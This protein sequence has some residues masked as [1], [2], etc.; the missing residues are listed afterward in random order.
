MKPAWRQYLPIMT[1]LPEYTRQAASKDG[2]AA[3]IVTLMLVPQSLAYAIVAGL[4]PVYGLYA[5]ILPLVAYTLLGT[6]KTLA[7]GPVAVISLMTAEAIAPLHD[8]GTHAYVT[9]AATL[10]FLS[11]LMLLIMAVF[12]LGF[13]TTFLSHS[14]LSGFMTASGVLII[15]GQL[16]KLLGLSAAPGSL[17][18]V[19]AAV[20]YP[21]LWLGVGTLV[22]LVLGRRYFASLLQNFGC[23]ASWAGHISKLLPVMVMVASILIIDYFP[24]HTQGVS[25]VGAIP[26]GLPSFVM[27]VFETNLVVQLLPA[28]LL[29]SV[30]GFVESASVGQTLAAKRRQRIEPNQELIA[31]G[32][33]NIASAIQGGFP[34]TGGTFSFSG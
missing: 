26:T 28:A 16:P 23:S 30:V 9:A 11:G 2:V 32:G 33:A 6:S 27:P 12:R 29:I 18:E 14:V 10:A 22:L 34:V 25:V 21:T 13:L 17:T 31:L 3:L 1:W 5:S 19:L 7:V 20:H 4:P 24:Q 15:W 8:V